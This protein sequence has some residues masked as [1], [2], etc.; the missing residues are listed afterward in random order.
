MRNIRS[1]LGVKGDKLPII[2]CADKADEARGGN[3]LKKSV[4]I[5]LDLERKNTS[6]ISVKLC[7]DQLRTTFGVS[8]YTM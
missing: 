2:V 5:R 3:D 1:S 8:N 4:R 7:G 6:L